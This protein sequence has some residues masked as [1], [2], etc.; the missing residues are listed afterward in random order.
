MPW[1]SPGRFKLTVDLP[2][3]LTLAFQ[4]TGEDWLQAFD[5]VATPTAQAWH[6]WVRELDGERWDFQGHGQDV[7]VFFGFFGMQFVFGRKNLYM[8]SV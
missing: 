6:L 4:K 3:P 2:F 5:E 1:Y 8:L 7:C